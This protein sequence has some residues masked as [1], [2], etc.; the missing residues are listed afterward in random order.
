MMHDCGSL[1]RY[2]ICAD[3]YGVWLAV[4]DSMYMMGFIT[5]HPWYIGG[6]TAESSPT[7]TGSAL[8]ARERGSMVIAICCVLLLFPVVSACT[9]ML[10]VCTTALF[11]RPSG[12]EPST[13]A[14]C[15]TFGL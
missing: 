8:V 11:M 12:L 1:F 7:P 3:K 2:G 9:S 4:T 10:G 6:A 5:R 14:V 13:A 15:D